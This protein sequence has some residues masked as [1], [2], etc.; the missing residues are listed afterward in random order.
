M[1]VS[2]RTLLGAVGGLAALTACDSSPTHTDPSAS[3]GGSE[4]GRP[5]Q[6]RVGPIIMAA[7][8]SLT[9][10]YPTPPFARDGS[11]AWPGV[12]ANGQHCRL[13]NISISGQTAAQ[14]AIRQGGIQ[15]VAAKA[16]RIP[17]DPS[18]SV[19]F[20]VTQK[21]PTLF[22]DRFLFEL[23]LAGVD[24]LVKQVDESTFTLR[25]RRPGRE[26]FVKQGSVA[27]SPSAHLDAFH[28]FAAGRNDFPATLK[29]G[30]V[31]RHVDEAFNAVHAM[32]RSLKAPSEGRFLM[33]GTI[34]GTNEKRGSVGYHAV[35]TFNER[36][37]EAYPGEFWDW[38][39]YLVQHALTDAHI[40]ST[41][42]DDEAVA[43]DTYPPSL[44]IDGLHYNTTA[45]RVVGLAVRKELIRRKVLQ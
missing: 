9:A 11:N 23:N 30:D 28:L 13:V 36:L 44:T 20:P 2:R 14:A 31:D 43:G 19:A 45:A 18:Y 5:G 25:P 17:A 15:L 26:T 38:R 16:L 32:V 4:S 10:G 39:A 29:A 12:M 40:S 34:T 35:T 6:D 8:D 22:K 37:R 21:I 24:I 1:S 7:G 41:S 33:M 27:H 3:T 42:H